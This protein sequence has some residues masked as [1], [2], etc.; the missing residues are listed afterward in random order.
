MHGEAGLA[1]RL[2]FV[3]GLVDASG[4]G[5]A[6]LVEP[7]GADDVQVVGQLVAVLVVQ[8]VVGDNAFHD[9]GDAQAGQFRAHETTTI[10]L[11]L[12]A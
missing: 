9:L 2:Q 4:D 3:Y 12:I 11:P 10:G 7:F 6:Q 8:V 5:E 1:L